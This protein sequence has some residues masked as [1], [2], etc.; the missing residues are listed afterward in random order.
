MDNVRVQQGDIYRI[1]GEDC[2]ICLVTPEYGVV[3]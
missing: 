1:D 3:S 2:C